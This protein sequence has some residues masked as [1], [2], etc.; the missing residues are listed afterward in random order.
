MD[1]RDENRK[2][3]IATVCAHLQAHPDVWSHVPAHVRAV[4]KL[5][6]LNKAIADSAVIQGMV[7]TG[8]TGAKT[9][10]RTRLEI[11]LLDVA[12]ALGSMADEDENY[13][14]GAQVNLVIST[15]EGLSEADLQSTSERV[16]QLGRGHADRLL[17]EHGLGAEDLTQSEKALENFGKAVTRPRQ[18]VSERAAQSELLPDLIREAT[19]LLDNRI[20]RQMNRLRHEHPE[21]HAAYLRARMIVDHGM[22]GVK[23]GE[24]E[25]APA[26][27]NGL[28]A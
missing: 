21:F 4:N 11:E 5:T 18:A 24:G 8:F 12:D 26:A 13:E 14:V 17:A 1:R 9:A 22:G 16:L 10:E 28:P 3:M 2:G 20:D 19:L 15:L 27:S 23:D 7:T 6:Q 25:A